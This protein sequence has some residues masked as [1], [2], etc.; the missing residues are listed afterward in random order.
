MGSYS[1]DSIGLKS[2]WYRKTSD[3]NYAAGR[4]IIE[5]HWNKVCDE[6][7]I[8]FVVQY[9]TFFTIFSENLIREIDAALGTDFENNAR[10]Y[11]IFLTTRAYEIEKTKRIWRDSYKSNRDKTY[12]CPY[13]D[14]TF[15]ILDCHPDI[16]KTL[17]IP[18]TH[19]RT[20]DYVVGRYS[21]FWDKEIKRRVHDMMRN[22][23]EEKNCELCQN[24][25]SLKDDIFT[26]YSFGK[27]FVDYFYP[28]LYLHICPKCFKKTFHDYKRGSSATKLSRLYDLFLF[29]GEIP[30]QDFDKLFY[31]Y[32]DHDS[33]CVLIEIFQKLRTP[34][35]YKEEFGSFFA[36]LVKS[37]ILPEGSKRMTIGTMVLADDGHLCLSL[38][39]KEIDDFLYSNDIPH[40]KEVY[41][42][43]CKMRADW[44][45]LGTK[46]R[47]LVEYFGLM[48]N[49]DYA[50][51]TEKKIKLA[52]ENNIELIEIYPESDW[53]VFLS[54]FIQSDKLE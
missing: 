49:K 51:K 24:R 48:N 1:P 7:L 35:G 11:E 54:R 34:Q 12:T 46:K 42:P 16:L 22:I 44:E 14:K 13:C 5:K 26:Y 27:Q 17:G 29:T 9:G 32:K 4:R 20:C 45:I 31:L 18:P 36:A 30:T 39:E 47:T 2:G 3:E 53:K 37:G 40:D 6:I 23:D 41:Y 21:S 50:E 8:K 52:A 28:N 25:F 38:P 33:L 19:C 43:G 15:P 10:Y